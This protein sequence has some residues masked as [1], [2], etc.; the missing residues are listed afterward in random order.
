MVD[1]ADVGAK[2]KKVTDDLRLGIHPKL[3]RK[4]YK[5]M[6]KRAVAT[7]VGM[8]FASDNRSTMR[9]SQCYEC[10]AGGC[11]DGEHCYCWCRYE[12]ATLVRAPACL[13]VRQAQRII[14]KLLHSLK[15][16]GLTRD[17]V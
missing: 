17:K 7:L 2:L 13:S 6:N 4:I 10:A 15:D 8:G 12:E 11:G 14:Y 16:R 5:I 9:V 3:K 1:S